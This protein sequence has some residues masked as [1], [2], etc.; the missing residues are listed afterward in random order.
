MKK[1]EKGL[2]VRCTSCGRK[3]SVSFDK[4][5]SKGYHKK[6]FFAEGIVCPE[7]AIDIPSDKEER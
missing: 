7:C 6:L 2:E 4:I 5:F 1:E 3:H